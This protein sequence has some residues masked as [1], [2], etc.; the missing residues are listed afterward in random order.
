[1]KGAQIS[2]PPFWPVPGNLEIHPHLA[3]ALGSS[4]YFLGNILETVPFCMFQL[5][6][7]KHE[8]L[9]ALLN[10]KEIT[11][12]LST[13][14]HKKDKV[15]QYCHPDYPELYKNVSANS[16]IQLTWR[17]YI[18]DLQVITQDSLVLKF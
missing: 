6:L 2:H 3:P 1:M 18:C 5:E 9:E 12:L 4:K 14:T 11:T 17:Y 13:N 8:S 15:F 10:T 16:A 7:H